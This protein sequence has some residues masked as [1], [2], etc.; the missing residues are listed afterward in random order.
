[1][2]KRLSLALVATLCLASAWTVG[3]QSASPSAAACHSAPSTAKVPCFQ[4]LL[5]A[6]LESQ[7][8]AASM[9]LLEQLVE[10]EPVVRDN[11]HMFAHMLGL[12]AYTTPGELATVFSKC[13]PNFQ[14]GCYHGVIQ[15][16]F[17]DRQRKSPGG[18]IGAAEINSLC[19]DFRGRSESWL[20]F[21][22][23]HGL[24]HGLELIYAHDLPRALKGC[25][26][27][28]SPWERAGCNGGAFMENVV[29]AT[30]PEQT[31]EHMTAG[32]GAHD[33]M[34]GMDMGSMDHSV[35]ATKRFK[36]FDPADPLYPCSALPERYGTECYGMQTSLILFE[37]QGDFATASSV[38]EASPANFR[39]TCFMSLGRDANSYAGN[40]PRAAAQNCMKAAERFRPW[41][42]VGVARNLV[43]LTSH[44]ADG[45]SYC[46]LLAD[47][48]SRVTCY[49]A[50]GEAITLLATAPARRRELCAAAPP[51]YDAACLYGARVSATRPDG[52]ASPR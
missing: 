44:P 6:R 29:S 48:P 4:R 38:C 13:S 9:T 26:L 27:V 35:G 40:D 50:I 36:A 25:D 28:A 2:R 18:E 12:A 52:L 45:F 1:M 7:G 21:Q 11:S 39:T 22:C 42:H 49:S 24:G 47:N 16:Y 8:V 31:A 34:A 51:P 17:V 10:T 33:D 30:N 15:A 41:C 37:K 5:D 19:R 23:A 3:A 43:D 14:S 32:D 46:A 20:L